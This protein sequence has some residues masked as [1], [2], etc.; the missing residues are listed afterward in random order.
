M[1][2]RYR[3]LF[4]SVGGVEVFAHMLDSLGFF[5]LIGSDISAVDEKASDETIHA[6]VAQHDYAVELLGLAKILQYDERGRV[7][8]VRSL[9]ARLLT[10]RK[11]E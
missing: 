7:G 5:E 3:T 2:A 4:A 9:A 1:E 8:N 11:D 6:R 10:D